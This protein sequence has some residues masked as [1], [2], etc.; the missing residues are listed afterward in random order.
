M[1]LIKKGI[2]AL[3]I[4]GLIVSSCSDDDTVTSTTGLTKTVLSSFSATPSGDGTIVTVTPLSIGASSYVVDFGD[5]NSTSD[6]LTI[7]EQNGSV[8]YDYPNEVE[9]VTYTISVTTKSDS[10]LADVTKSKDLQVTHSPMAIDSTP[11]S[12][13][14]N[15]SDV[16]AVFSDG[17]DFKG[18]M[19]SWEN[20]IDAVTAKV[21]GSGN[22]VLEFSRLGAKS[23]VLALGTEDK[24]EN[25]VIEHAFAKPNND[26]LVGIGA[27]RIQFDVH[28]A[29]AEGIDKLKITLINGDNDDEYVIDGID[30]TD[31]AWATFDYDLATDFSAPVVRID[32]IKFEL[33]TGGT[34]NDHATINVDNIILTKAPSATILNG[35]FDLST[36]QWRFATF[37]DGTTTPFGSSSDGAWTDYDGTPRTKKSRG[38]KWTTSQ[39]GG[40]QQSSNSRYAYQALTLIPNT[41]YVL[42]YE[43]A[44]DDDNDND[45]IG[46]RRMVGAI[47]NDHYIDGADAVAARTSNLGN[48]VGTIAEG[49]FNATR[50]TKVLIP[51]TSND[52]GKVAVWFYAVT[53][54]DAWID[55]VK[56]YIAP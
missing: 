19:I 13:T 46:G 25:V 49:K 36:A 53:V 28:S 21:T 11:A 42:E 24:P 45:P 5:P 1:N 29:F 4:A 44:I 48:H 39:S 22:T 14:K 8:S 34:A 10:G 51:F 54:D 16:F 32:E 31:G 6:V 30:L 3:L 2:G 40:I 20:R 9:K 38:A 55:N 50:G 37:T 26:D 41:N 33:G 15:D 27:T 47:L 43:Y 17:K 35:G 56:V 18:G 52:S 7:S 12:P 23:G